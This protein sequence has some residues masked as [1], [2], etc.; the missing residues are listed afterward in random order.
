MQSMA[1]RPNWIAVVNIEYLVSAIKE[2][3]NQFKRVRTTA[4]DHFAYGSHGESFF[5]LDS[6][7]GKLAV[8]YSA[9]FTNPRPIDRDYQGYPALDERTPR[10]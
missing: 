8:G 7:R 9:D 1:G 3:Y 2:I 4:A 5:L 10:R 6:A